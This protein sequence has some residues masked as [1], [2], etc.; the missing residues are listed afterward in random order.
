MSRPWNCGFYTMFWEEERY[1]ESSGDIPFYPF[2]QV[3][4]SQA[5]LLFKSIL[6]ES[7][8]GGCQMGMDPL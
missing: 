8:P 5:V 4:D 7:M 2:V 3:N 1:V 6:G